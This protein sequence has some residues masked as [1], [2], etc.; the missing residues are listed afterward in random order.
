MTNDVQDSAP[1]VLRRD[2]S[3]AAESLAALCA[4][5]EDLQTALRCCE[6]LV[7]QLT[8]VPA[9]LRAGPVDDLL[10][11]AVWTLALLSYARCFR[12][13]AG[14][15]AGAESG[16]GPVLSEEDVATTHPGTKVLQ[17]H[18]VLLSLRDHYADVAVNPREHFTVGV[19]Q[20][21]GGTASGIGVTSTREPLVDEV[22]VR[23]MGA[24]AYALSVVVDARIAQGQSALFEEVKRVPASDLDKREAFEVLPDASHSGRPSTDADS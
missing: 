22:T 17:W 1:S 20:D 16:T 24:I 10:V 18:S 11:E 23:Q 2:Q 21:S 6:R 8:A 14:A 15:G 3:P 12:A 7:S 4:T 9:P 13:G 19:A 5:F